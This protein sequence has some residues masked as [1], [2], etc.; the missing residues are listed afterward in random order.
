MPELPEVEVTRRSFADRIAGARITGVRLGK[1]LRWPLGVQPQ[2]L[3]GRTV[4]GVRRRGKYLL[5]DLDHGL[6]LVHLGMSGSLRFA[7]GLPPAGPHD[8]VD[9]QTDRGVLRLHDPRRFGAVVHAAHEAAP[10][11]RKLLGGLGVEPLS[12][13][14][15][16]A[17]FHAALR[18]HRSSIKQVLLA[19]GIVVGVGNIYASEALF[20]A[21]IRPTTRADRIGRVRAE[22]LHAAI[23]QVLA[24]ALEVGGSSLKDF[25][26]A[27]GGSGYFQL[28]TRVYG[29]EGQPCRVC[30]TVVRHIRQGQRSTFFCPVCQR[31]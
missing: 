31:R 18:R 16:P 6:L 8:H 13:D 2:S 15:E 1:P 4:Q 25:V 20:M 5:L 24:R 14:F 11:A 23:R 29:R 21:G 12:A 17:A 7:A 28:E 26:D 9:V 22:R 30:G 19:G 3:V 27:Q 10:E